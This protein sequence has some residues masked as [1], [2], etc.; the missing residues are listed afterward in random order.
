MYA[1]V[2]SMYNESDSITDKYPVQLKFKEEDALDAGGVTRD[3][4]S[5]FWEVAFQELFDGGSL[6]SPATHSDI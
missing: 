3:M 4:Y 1:D 6:L 2:L 5:A